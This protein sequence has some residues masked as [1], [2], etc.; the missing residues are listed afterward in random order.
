MDDDDAAAADEK[1]EELYHP[2]VE[3]EVAPSSLLCHS[4]GLLLL[5]RLEDHLTRNRP[6]QIKRTIAV[7]RN[8]FYGWFPVNGWMNGWM[9]KMD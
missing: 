6:F 9:N 4:R 3:V 1:D 7:L 8:R 2:V 5:L